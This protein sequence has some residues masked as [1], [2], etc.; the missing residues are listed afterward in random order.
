[1]TFGQELYHS[2]TLN[3]LTQHELADRVG[4]TASYIS[5]LENDNFT[6]PPSDKMINAL[7]D[8]L[9]DYPEF[10]FIAAGKLDLKRLQEIAIS[11]QHITK[12]LRHIQ[13][14]PTKTDNQWNR[15]LTILKENE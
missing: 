1:M 2:R 13:N 11:S 3:K 6:V 8:E 5:K 7:A 14:M 15:I 10:M 4:C 12:V 9:G